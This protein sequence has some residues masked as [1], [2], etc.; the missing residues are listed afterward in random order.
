[1]SFWSAA[2]NI[3]KEVGGAVLEETKAA[4]ARSRQYK[5]EMP[6]KSENE[7]I[8]IVKKERSRSPMK[9]GAASLELKNRG[10]DSE[11]IKAMIR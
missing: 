6:N 9:A 5:E 1:M 8:S 2:G 11:D 7:L 3:A 10:F 4:G